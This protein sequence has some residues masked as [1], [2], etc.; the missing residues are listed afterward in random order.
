MLPGGA[1]ITS[2]SWEGQHTRRTRDERVAALR[3][4]QP[5]GGRGG[6]RR[7]RGPA[8]WRRLEGRGGC[9]PAVSSV[10]SSCSARPL[11]MMRWSPTARL[12]E[13][14][15]SATGTPSIFSRIRTNSSK[16]GWHR[17]SSEKK[18]V[19]FQVTTEDLWSGLVREF[20][21][22]WKLF[23]LDESSQSVR[24]FTVEVDTSIIELN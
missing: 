10:S 11:N 23:S 4:A 8:H 6:P 19:L 16:K 20:V 7:A 3:A 17:F 12:V 1:G 15:T 18:I 22:K 14:S 13:S 5:D 21:D 24:S 2:Y 9:T